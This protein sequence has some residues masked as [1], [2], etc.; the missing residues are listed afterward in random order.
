MVSAETRTLSLICQVLCPVSDSTAPFPLLRENGFMSVLREIQSQ[1]VCTER[2]T[3]VSPQIGAKL[4][5]H[6]QQ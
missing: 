5:V 3:D 4:S 1:R 2:Q 6:V